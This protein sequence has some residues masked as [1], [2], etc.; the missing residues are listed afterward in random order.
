MSMKSIIKLL[1]NM[2]GTEEYVDSL[3]E[4]TLD[5][6]SKATPIFVAAD[7]PPVKVGRR[8]FYGDDK[9]SVYLLFKLNDRILI[10]VSEFE[11]DYDTEEQAKEPMHSFA[12]REVMEDDDFK[13]VLLEDDEEYLQECFDEILLDKGETV[14]QFVHRNSIWLL[15]LS[16]N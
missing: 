13:D 4:K 6:V 3:K 16:L 15:N 7:A 11:L 5:I 14:E 10:Y 8:V 12:L 1:S 9:K 2:Q